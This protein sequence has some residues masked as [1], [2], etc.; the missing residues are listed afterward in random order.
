[1]SST[2]GNSSFIA[3]WPAWNGENE[4]PWMIGGHGASAWGLL[5]QA[6][7]ATVAAANTTATST[8][9]KKR[10]ARVMREG[11][12]PGRGVKVSC[13]LGARLAPP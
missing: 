11:G 2:E 3:S 13:T 8:P 5:T 6:Q 9:A 4:K 10:G 12:D 7:T 1:M